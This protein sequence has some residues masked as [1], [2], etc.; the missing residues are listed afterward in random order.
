[1]VAQNVCCIKYLRRHTSDGRDE[2]VWI[3]YYLARVILQVPSEL[4][5]CMLDARVASSV[6]SHRI[7]LGLVI[8]TCVAML[9]PS[10]ASGAYLETLFF[11]CS[12]FQ[13]S[14]LFFRQLASFDRETCSV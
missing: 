14:L 12:M 2:E 6:H 9:W 10:C 5:C 11:L 1:M 4:G 13:L 8:S 7:C 3:S